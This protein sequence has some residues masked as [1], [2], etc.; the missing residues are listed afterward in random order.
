[1]KESRYD[2]LAMS[3]AESVRSKVSKAKPGTLFVVDEF[4]GPR[5]PIETALSRLEDRGELRRVRKGLYFKGVGS[6]F[7]PGK[8]RTEDVVYKVCGTRGVGP[9][10][11]T[12][13]RALGLSTQLPA[14]PEFALV[15]AAP[16]NVP[17]V[18]FHTR[19]NLERID[20][21]PREIAV[22]ETLRDW[23]AYS[24]ATWDDLV[25]RVAELR[26]EG[27]IKPERLAKVASRERSPGLRERTA[28][29]L[30]DLNVGE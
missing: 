19:K 26:D 14:F 30:S 23:P 5:S 1:M 29:L 22:L 18:R 28:A 8:P 25:E 3:V 11:W 24:E 21:N 27:A 13:T 6:R 2:F 20:L 15:G 4:D 16:T 9:A 17:G 10:G 7:G 12:A